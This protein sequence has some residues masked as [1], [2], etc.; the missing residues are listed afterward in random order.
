MKNPTWELAEKAAVNRRLKSPEVQAA[1]Q[2][3]GVRGDDILVNVCLQL[4]FRR[5]VLDEWE[6]DQPTRMKAITAEVL[7]RVR[8]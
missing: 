2:K 1:L 4:E 5:Q 6:R 7:G 3:L 8:E